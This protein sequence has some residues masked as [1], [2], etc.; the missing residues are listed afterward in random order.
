MKLGVTIESGAARAVPPPPARARKP[1]KALTVIPCDPTPVLPFGPPVEVG[2]IGAP[3][4]RFRCVPLA[5]VLLARDCLK[6]QSIAQGTTQPEEKTSTGGARSWARGGGG[7]FL[8]EQFLKCRDCE[9]GR[10]V[11]KRLVS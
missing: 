7:S 5:A 3:E 8:R 4:D 9:L 1:R 2:Q 11:K 6:R 10:A